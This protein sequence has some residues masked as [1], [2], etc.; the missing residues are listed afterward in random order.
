MPAVNAF[1][2][3]GLGG[4]FAIVMA[5]ASPSVLAGVD[6][7]LW[8]IE[9]NGSPPLKLCVADPATLAQF[10]HR[11]A[12][13]ARDFTRDSGSGATVHYS[14]K[15]GGFGQSEVTVIT[16]RSVRVQT[17]GISGGSPFKYV[18]QARRVGDCGGH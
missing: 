16:P 3:A 18:F 13:C 10:E 6:G 5:A 17:Q 14:C 2:K 12:S 4:L 11:T 8:E 1:A 15:G 7:G 9:R